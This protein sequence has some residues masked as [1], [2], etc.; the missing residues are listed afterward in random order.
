MKY[1]FRMDKGK[2]ISVS[3]CFEED[4]FLYR[5]RWDAELNNWVDD[6]AL[7]AVAKFGGFHDYKE[8]TEKEAMQ[9]IQ[10]YSQNN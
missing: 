2:P 8:T 6:L 4:D 1:Y 7:I 9:F 3:R 5:E 10:A